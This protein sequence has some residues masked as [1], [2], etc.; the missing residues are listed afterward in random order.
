MATKVITVRVPEHLLAL[1]P[2]ASLSKSGGRSDYVNSAIRE[3]LKREGLL[4]KA[5]EPKVRNAPPPDM[6]D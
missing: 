3:K 1:M 6:I 5:M 4:T 2:P